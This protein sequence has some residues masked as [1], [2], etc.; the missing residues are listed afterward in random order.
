MQCISVLIGFYIAHL[1]SFRTSC[2]IIQKR[3]IKIRTRSFCSQ[4]KSV[5]NE[6]KKTVLKILN[7]WNDS[8]TDILPRFATVFNYYA[9]KDKKKSDFLAVGTEL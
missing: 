5:S 3:L 9:Q 1:P 4:I 7:N 8:K 2:T 6:T